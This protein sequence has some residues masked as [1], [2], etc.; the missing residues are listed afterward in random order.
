[1]ATRTSL[2]TQSCLD[3]LTAKG[4]YCWRSNNI[5]VS[6]IENGKRTFRKFNGMKGVSDILAVAP[7]PAMFDETSPLVWKSRSGCIWC[8]EIKTAKD[9]QSPDQ[10]KFQEQIEKRGGIYMIVRDTIDELD[11]RLG[12]S[13][14]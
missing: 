1:M 10:K 8:I 2:L 3:L 9:K 13:G 11:W 4:F 14:F 12:L 7:H 5:P 6:V